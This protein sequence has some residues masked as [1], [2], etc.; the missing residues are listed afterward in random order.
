MNNN[1]LRKQPINTSNQ[2]QM[3]FKYSLLT[4]V[5]I[6]CIIELLYSNIQNITKNINHQSKIK[7]LEAKKNEELEKNKFL[8]SEIENF[9]SDE[10]LESIL[11]TKKI[12][13]KK[14]TAVLKKYAKKPPIRRLFAL[15]NYLT[16][17]S[18]KFVLISA[19]ISL[20]LAN[21]IILRFFAPFKK[22]STPSDILLVG[23][24]NFVFIIIYTNYFL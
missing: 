16:E 5:L 10:I 18:L 14:K 1:K 21:A 6:V 24:I 22:N 12:Q 13:N 7:A 17:T 19:L 15:T 2:R 9:N 8:K 3:K 20:M 4:I 23:I 11:I